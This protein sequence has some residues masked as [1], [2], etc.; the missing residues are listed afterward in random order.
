[1]G[2]TMTRPAQAIDVFF[3]VAVM[4]LILVSERA[5]NAL[6]RDRVEVAWSL[7]LTAIVLAVGILASYGYR[8]LKRRP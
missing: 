5:V 4:V 7:A 3:V 2:V 6:L 1:M 8:A